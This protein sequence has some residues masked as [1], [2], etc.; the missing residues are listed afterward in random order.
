VATLNSRILQILRN[1][2]AN[3]WKKKGCSCYRS[4]LID[5]SKESEE[6][7]QFMEDLGFAYRLEYLGPTRETNGFRL[8]ALLLSHSRIFQGLGEI[9]TYG[10]NLL[11]SPSREAES[12]SLSESG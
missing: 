7:I 1:S 6:A 11:V 4:L 3:A 2:V 5:D 9:K 12:S 10:R 8:P